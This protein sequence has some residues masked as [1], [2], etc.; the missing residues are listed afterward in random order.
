MSDYRCHVIYTIPVYSYSKI[1][2]NKCKILYTY[3]H[4]C[5]CKLTYINKHCCKCKLDY[6]LKHC[7]ECKVGYRNK[8]CCLCK[9][10][11][12]TKHCCE[13]KIKYKFSHCCECKLN[14]KYKHC[15]LHGS[16]CRNLYKGGS[17]YDSEGDFLYDFSYK[18]I[19]YCPCM[20]IQRWYRKYKRIQILWKIAEY[21]SAKKYKPG[22]ILKYIKL[23]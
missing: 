19:L 17:I 21:Y 22:N 11:F 23:D 14:Y 9:V 1:L 10:D 18:K 12:K 16:I 13:C 8:H 2:C 4:C 15:C 6:Q 3:K 5:K 20:I 7:C